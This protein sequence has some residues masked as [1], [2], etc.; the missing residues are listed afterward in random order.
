[1]E[2]HGRNDQHG[3]IDFVEL[4]NERAGILEFEAG[5][6]RPKAEYEAALELRKRYGLQNLPMVIR[7]IGNAAYRKMMGLPDREMEG[8]DGTY[9][10]DQA[11]VLD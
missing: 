8:Q 6:S 2:E 3:R 9:K 10:N 1:M 5:M 11:R 4:F 7:E